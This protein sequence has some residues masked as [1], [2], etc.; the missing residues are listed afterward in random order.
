MA[1]ELSYAMQVT[2]T[3]NGRTLQL[4]ATTITVDVTGNNIVSGV[5]LATVA[6]A[7]AVPIGAIGTSGF[8]VFRN[9]DATN[10][11]N[12]GVD[13]AGLVVQTKLLAGEQCMMRMTAAP[14]VQA[15]TADCLLS[16]TVIEN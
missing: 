8:A 4:P 15:D 14:Y 12:I 10:Y 16:Y 7:V 5:M 11:V 6:S 9:L 1:D 3:H 2:Y 13:S